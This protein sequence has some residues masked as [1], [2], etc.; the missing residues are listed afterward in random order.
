[1]GVE[2]MA[3]GRDLEP[4]VLQDPWEYSAFYDYN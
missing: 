2:R 4:V 3:C 1:M